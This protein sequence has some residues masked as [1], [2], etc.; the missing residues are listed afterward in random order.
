MHFVRHHLFELARGRRV[1][2]VSFSLLILKVRLSF[3]IWPKIFINQ[4]VNWKSTSKKR[5]NVFLIS[6]SDFFLV[7]SILFCRQVIVSKQLLH[8]SREKN[9]HKSKFI[10]WKSRFRHIQIRL[11]TILKQFSKIWWAAA[12]NRRTFIYNKIR[13]KTFFFRCRRRLLIQFIHITY[14]PYYRNIFVD[15]RIMI[16]HFPFDVNCHVIGTENWNATNRDETNRN[17][18][19]MMA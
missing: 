11:W 4:S 8:L 9:L 7:L 5:K 14:Q 16:N 10:N 2:R 19:S 13:E 15:Q 17:I 6:H 18:F 3:G 12:V 1:V